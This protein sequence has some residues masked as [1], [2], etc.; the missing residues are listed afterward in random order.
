[1]QHYWAHNVKSSA[2]KL[3]CGTDRRKSVHGWQSFLWF[4]SPWQR[5][6]RSVFCLVNYTS[7]NALCLTDNTSNLGQIFA[8]G[9]REGYVWVFHLCL[10]N[11]ELTGQSSHTKLAYS[12]WICFDAFQ[13][14]PVR[15][16]TFKSCN[17]SCSGEWRKVVNWCWKWSWY[18]LSYYGVTWKQSWAIFWKQIV[19][20]F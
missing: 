3:R 10:C 20:T 6:C 7:I 19:L 11:S 2:W 16:M 4:W 12:T 18:L 8:V 5:K 15:K 14:K 1:M 17:W 13:L 9:T